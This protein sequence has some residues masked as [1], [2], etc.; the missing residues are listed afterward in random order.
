VLDTA[1][2]VITPGIVPDVYVFVENPV[3]GDTTLYKE[4]FVGPVKLIFQFFICTVNTSG[5]AN[6]AGTIKRK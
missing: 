6:I 3:R 5:P 4:V 2:F 1:E